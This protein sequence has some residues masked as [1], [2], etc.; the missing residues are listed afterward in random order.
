MASSLV[1]SLVLD[2]TW[3]GLD[4]FLK[5]KKTFFRKGSER[6][7]VSRKIN[8]K[9]RTFLLTY[10]CRSAA[11]APSLLSGFSSK[12]G[13]LRHKWKSYRHCRF[14]LKYFWMLHML[15][16]IKCYE[17]STM[18]ALGYECLCPKFLHPHY[19]W[20]QNFKQILLHMVGFEYPHHCVVSHHWTCIHRM[21]E[22][23]S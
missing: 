6:N 20:L 14:V 11:L 7:L 10:F 23:R 12:S 5:K 16:K 4:L 18:V 15:N 17:S 3:V 9:T 1:V 8:S 19:L 13:N 21:T 22:Y 2:K